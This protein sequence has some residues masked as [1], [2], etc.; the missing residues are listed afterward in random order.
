MS[1]QHFGDGHEFKTII[2]SFGIFL[3]LYIK[4]M[5][6]LQHVWNPDIIFEV[7]KI[8]KSE[9]G[10]YRKFPSDWTRWRCKLVI[11]DSL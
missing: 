5:N 4:I 10:F 2:N 7:L 3:Q 8:C 11:Y 6:F 1:V 9:M